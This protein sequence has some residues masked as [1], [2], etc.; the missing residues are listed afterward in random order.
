MAEGPQLSAILLSSSYLPS[1]PLNFLFFFL[2]HS[3]LINQHTIQ[4]RVPQY[5]SHK[6]HLPCS[7]NPLIKRS[8][9]PQAKQDRDSNP[10][11]LSPEARDIQ[12]YVFFVKPVHDNSIAQ[13]HGKPC[14]KGTADAS[15]ADGQRDCQEQVQQASA[16]VDSCSGIIPVHSL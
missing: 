5:L 1:N 13:K 8:T 15:K 2:I 12:P 7:R 9:H 10:A 4:Y 6:Q 11:D 16:K 14:S 3:Q